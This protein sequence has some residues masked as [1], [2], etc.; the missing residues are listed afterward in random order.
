MNIIQKRRNAKRQALP[1]F[2]PPPPPPT[3]PPSTKIDDDDRRDVREQ[4]WESVWK[5]DPYSGL[6]SGYIYEAYLAGYP[7]DYIA[8]QTGLPREYI[9]QLISLL[10]E[11][12]RATWK[13]AAEFLRPRVITHGGPFRF[14]KLERFYAALREA[15]QNI[16]MGKSTPREELGR[17]VKNFGKIGVKKLTWKDV[18]EG[19]KAMPGKI[20][21]KTAE[22]ALRAGED[23][24][25]YITRN[26]NL[27]YRDEIFSYGKWRYRDPLKEIGRWSFW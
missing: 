18:K 8:K 25:W 12:E 22:W 10:E 1:P 4:M 7:I 15:N 3:P 6:A 13:I 19:I 27:W 23:V 5:K 9:V 26:P 2:A 11:R 17:L 14:E 21:D 16:M 20:L 24:L